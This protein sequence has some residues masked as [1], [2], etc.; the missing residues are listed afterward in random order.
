MNGYSVGLSTK[1]KKSWTSV[2]EDFD[3]G[4][5]KIIPYDKPVHLYCNMSEF[6][7][8]GKEEIVEDMIIRVLKDVA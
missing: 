1:D 5:S 2:R 3:M 6:I 4:I 7:R 8:T